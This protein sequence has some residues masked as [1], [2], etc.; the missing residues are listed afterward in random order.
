MK[1]G[2]KTGIVVEDVVTGRGREMRFAIRAAACLVVSLWSLSALATGGVAGGVVSA[3]RV[4]TLVRSSQ[5]GLARPQTLIIEDRARLEQVLDRL[6]L[7]GDPR[8]SKLDFSQQQVVAVF[9]GQKPSAGYKLEVARVEDEG[10]E[11]VVVVNRYRPGPECMTISVV[12]YPY[13]LAAIPRSDKPVSVQMVD[14]VRH[15]R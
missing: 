1:A 2:G 12:T 8:V 9:M 10:D 6:R 14:K 13:V 11:L 15:C 5:G 7:D 4:R 3:P